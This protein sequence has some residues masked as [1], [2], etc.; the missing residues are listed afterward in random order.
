MQK[1]TEEK[2]RQL[3]GVFKSSQGE[4]RNEAQISLIAYLDG[5]LSAT[6]GIEEESE[7]LCV[8]D[9]HFTWCYDYETPPTTVPSLPEDINEETWTI[10]AIIKGHN[11]LLAYLRAKEHHE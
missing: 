8:S 3:L 2:L 4:K 10:D 11:R 1:N 5:C 7:C 9:S 6:L